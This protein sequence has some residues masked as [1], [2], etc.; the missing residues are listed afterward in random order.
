MEGENLFGVSTEMHYPLLKPVYFKFDFL[1]AEFSIL[2]FGVVA[3]A[4]ADAGTV[5]FRHQPF[6][7]NNFAKGYGVGI[8]FILPYSWIL[9]TE[10]AWNEMRQGEFILDLGSSF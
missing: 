8:H 6:A 7:V 4:F 5:W 10:Y 1:P 2:K 9:R 3:A